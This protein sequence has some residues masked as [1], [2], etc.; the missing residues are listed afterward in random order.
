MRATTIV[1]A[2][3]LALPGCDSVDPPGNGSDFAILAQAA[4]GFAEARSEH[5]LEFPRDHG[6]HPDFR[7]EWWYLT[8][9][10]SG[11]DG[12]TYGAQWTLFRT[13]VEPPGTTQATNAWQSG[14][15]YMAHFAL[16]ESNG[17]RAFQRYARG[18]LQEQEA[19]SGAIAEPFSVWL[20]DWKMESIET[21][22]LPLQVAARQDDH[23]MSLLLASDRS[24]VL[25]GE[26]GF[27]LKHPGGG[28]SYYYS[29]PFLQASGELKID[30]RRV[31]VKGNA[32]LDREWSSQFLQPDQSGWD[33]FSL[34]LDSGEKL[35]LFRL[36]GDNSPGQSGVDFRHGVLI[37]PDGEK[38][39][40]DPAQID[41]QVVQTEPVAGRSLPLH[42]R[43]HLPEINRT[44][45]VRALH[46]DQWMDVDFPY[47]E[48]VV[49]ASGE[50]PGNSG[51]GYLELTG[52]SD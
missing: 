44:L 17:H 39:T 49:I 21:G 42:W 30:G 36:R 35:M 46:P 6:A 34:H 45:E 4:E 33:W 1:L 3:I 27:S 12:Q 50:G 23:A 40:L 15:V 14:Q 48:G 31:T 5:T 26:E 16:S 52:Y 19:R 7:I 20:D 28:G 25:Q 22:F 11:D 29:H 8:A 9:N 2:A 38:Q 37:E 47:W 10:L 13:A 51:K 32:W 43:I 24:L 41:L 18:G